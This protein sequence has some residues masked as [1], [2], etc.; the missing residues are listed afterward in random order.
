M[1]KIVLKK[2]KDT[3][4]EFDA[5]N[6]RFL[7]NLY[8]QVEKDIFSNKFFKNM[9]PEML[10]FF[11][12]FYMLRLFFAFKNKEKNINKIAIINT[13][14]L[15]SKEILSTAIIK[16]INI[17]RDYKNVKN[18]KNFIDNELAYFEILLDYL[19]FENAFAY[20]SE[21]IENKENKDKS[22]YDKY[23][24]HYGK[25]SVNN[26]D[27][28]S[29]I[30]E[31]N[32][33]KNNNEEYKLWNEFIKNEYENDGLDILFELLEEF[34]IKRENGILCG[35]KKEFYEAI[36]T[37][38]DIKTKNKEDNNN[39]IVDE[40]TIELIKGIIKIILVDEGNIFQKYLDSEKNKDI[41]FK[42]IIN[43]IGYYLG[44]KLL[45]IKNEE[46]PNNL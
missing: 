2:I 6:S 19:Y 22:I 7:L 42:P 39:I 3:L 33:I 12:R 26:N 44:E 14:N 37:L 24:S 25:L 1:T 45:R 15:I 9:N 27:N 31:Y 18:D 38:L 28:Y 30:I 35:C 40:K 5:L 21:N 8:N 16:M 34:S 10:K 20:E 4:K 11:N 46:Q 13:T 17:Y 36:F 43:N 32:W 23:I 41:I 29:Y